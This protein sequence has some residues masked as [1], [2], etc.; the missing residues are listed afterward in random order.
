MNLSTP[1]FPKQWTV[2]DPHRGGQ[3]GEILASKL[4]NVTQTQDGAEG[5]ADGVEVAAPYIL[6]CQVR[7]QVTPMNHKTIEK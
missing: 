3:I 5:L 7:K 6:D 4:D 2:I 1:A